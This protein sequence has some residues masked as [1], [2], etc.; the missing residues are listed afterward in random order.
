MWQTIH[1]SVMKR[2]KQMNFFV[3]VDTVIFTINPDRSVDAR[4]R[5]EVLVMQRPERPDKSKWALPGGLVGEDE[6]LEETS[7]RKVREETGIQLKPKELHQ[8]AAFGNPERDNRY[9]AIAIA[10][11]ALVPHP[12]ATKAISHSDKAEFIPYRLLRDKRM[13]EFDHT[14]IIYS[15]R[16]A[17]RKMLEDTSV[18]LNFCGPKFTIS[19]LRGVY[20]AFLQYEVDPANFRRKVDAVKDFVIPLDE[21]ADFGSSPGRPA[22]MYKP[23]R[24]TSLP[25]PIRFRRPDGKYVEK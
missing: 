25:T 21:Y 12:G 6:R 24:L 11:V 20:E 17:A 4:D 23:G 13:L 10:Y 15:A 8:V 14:D 2:T 16:K 9:R 22:L 7:I 3:Y 1:M 19:E 18:A 5:L